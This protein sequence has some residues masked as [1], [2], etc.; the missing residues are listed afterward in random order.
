MN[1]SRST[2]VLMEQVIMVLV[3]AL[4]AALCVQVFV[5]ASLQSK[6]NDERDRAVELA[7]STAETIKHAGGLA[8]ARE[9]DTYYDENWMADND[10]TGYAYRLD[11][12]TL[13]GAVDG[14]GQAAVR[15]LKNTDEP[16]DE[17]LVE[18]T[19][20]WQEVDAYA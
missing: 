19:V 11:I 2:L 3:F 6:G 16:D 15:V 1:H 10:T 9:M 18:L 5:Y 20:A 4:A 14:L 13:G 7:Q 17:V 8:G 12:H